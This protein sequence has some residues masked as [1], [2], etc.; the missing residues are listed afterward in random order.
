MAVLSQARSFS[1]RG[2]IRLPATKHPEGFSS[3]SLACLSCLFAWLRKYKIVSCLLVSGRVERSS[4]IR[5]RGD[6]RTKGRCY[7]S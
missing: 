1:P 4:R 3:P 2:P 5:F 6:R 7:V